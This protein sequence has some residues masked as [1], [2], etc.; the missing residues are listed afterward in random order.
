MSKVM[1]IVDFQKDFYDK[2]NGSLYVNGAENIV[3]NI[4]EE[5]KN[6]DYDSVILTLD[7]HD[8]TD[9]SF[10]C[11]GGIWPVHCVQKSDGSKIHPS[12]LD[13]I[14]KNNVPCSLFFKGNIYSH[15]EYG[16]FENINKIENNR[17]VLNNF[18]NNSPITLNENTEFTVC[19]LAGD[20]CV[21][22]TFCRLKKFGL[23]VTPFYNGMAFIG[24]TFNYLEKWKEKKEHCY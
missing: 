9:L 10:K 5:I 20:Y 2:E 11:N 4:C 18:A 6:G 8:N 13:A 23:N 7:W 19:G 12:I 16:A 1:V 3:N 15:E 22:E 21:W 14:E 24:E 17:I